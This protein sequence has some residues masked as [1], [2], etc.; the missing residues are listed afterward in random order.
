MFDRPKWEP[1]THG[2]GRMRWFVR[3]PSLEGA[4]YDYDGYDTPHYWRYRR[5]ASEAAAQCR[6]DELN[7]ET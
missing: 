4:G 3:R 2:A 1:F 6:C 7:R 5:F